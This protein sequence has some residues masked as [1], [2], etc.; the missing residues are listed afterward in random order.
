MI[1]FKLSSTTLRGHTLKIYKPQVHLDVRNNFFF[2]VR[3][4]DLWNSL[5][6]SLINCETIATL[7]K[8]SW[9]I[10]KQSGIYMYISFFSFFPLVK[11]LF[12]LGWLVELSWV[13]TSRDSESRCRFQRAWILSVCV[14]QQTKKWLAWFWKHVLW[15]GPLYMTWL[16][17]FWQVFIC[18]CVPLSQQI[19][20]EL[21]SFSPINVFSPSKF[22]PLSGNILIKHFASH[23][24]ITI[25]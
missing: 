7:K 4:I 18:L 12:Y 10:T 14:C 3:I 6:I 19:S 21:L 8:T 1:F 23:F 24:S 11:P 22:N 13:I 20:L 15:R 17:V 2:T 16:S 9:V 5:P 25:F